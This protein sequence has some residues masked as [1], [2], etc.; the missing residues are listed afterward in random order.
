ME[1]KGKKVLVFGSGIS[2]ESA[3][4]LLLRK[5][6]R[7]ILYDGN[8]K[9]DAEDIIGKI[10]ENLTETD[11]VN[12]KA[13][14]QTADDCGDPENLSV[15]LGEFPEELLGGLSLI[16]MSTGVPTDLPVVNRMKEAGIPI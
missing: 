6:A 11:S 14:G 3:A 12:G 16:V 15:V 8:E 10:R 2:G 7:V 4:G 1:I 13:P 5:G 9:L